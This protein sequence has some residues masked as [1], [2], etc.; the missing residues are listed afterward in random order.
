VGTADA[1]VF[2]SDRE[3]SNLSIQWCDDDGIP[4]PGRQWD[5][6]YGQT[7]DNNE[8]GRF[9]SAYSSSSRVGNVWTIRPPFDLVWPHMFDVI[10]D[11]VPPVGGVAGHFPV[12]RGGKYKTGSGWPSPINTAIT[13]G[14]S[15]FGFLLVPYA[16]GAGLGGVA[17]GDFYGSRS[18][19]YIGSYL[20]VDGAGGFTGACTRS[21]AEDACAPRWTPGAGDIGKIHALAYTVSG[22]LAG[23]DLK[24][25][26]NG[27]L[28][29]TATLQS[30]LSSTGEIRIGYGETPTSQASFP[31]IGCAGA[32]VV[33]R[34]MSLVEIQ[35]WIQR[36]KDVGS[37]ALPDLADTTAVIGW[38]TP[39][40]NKR[41]FSARSNIETTPVPPLVR[42]T[43]PSGFS[44]LTLADL[45]F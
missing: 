17:N 41:T 29:G 23:A 39:T 45:A 19:S 5:V 14:P 35:A 32:F 40:A 42:V 27:A 43:A 31:N 10:V 13:Q 12:E 28:I 20:T 25:Y 44:V 8:N 30:G 4:L 11:E 7:D 33:N 1:L 9:A 36:I 21:G 38:E 16:V 15:T 18:S 22:P 3:L 34:V 37:F 2:T 6:V 26:A 24:F